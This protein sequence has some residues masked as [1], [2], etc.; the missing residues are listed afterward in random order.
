MN[1]LLVNPSSA[2]A[3]GKMKSPVQMHMGLA[4][5]AAVLEKNKHNVDIMDIDAEGINTEKFTELVKTRKYSIAGFTM[6]TPT[7]SSS[8]KLAELVK[9]HSPQT[10]TV[11]GGIHP[12][13]KPYEVAD[14]ECVDVVVKGEGEMALS[15][16]AEYVE[17]G[18][19]L[20][21]IKGIAYTKNGQVQ[22]SPP[23]L[24][25][26]DL[27]SIPFPARHLFKVKSYTYPDA[28][29]GDT[30]PIFTSR[31]CPGRCTFC[32]S[33][34][35]FETKVRVRSAR[36]VVDEIEYLTNSLHVKEIHVWDDNFTTIKDRVFKIRDEI[37]KR[38]LKVKF[39]FPNGIRADFLNIDIMKAL[40]DMG[41]YS[42]A[43]G[44][45]SGSQDVLDMAHKGVKLEKVEEIF[46]LARKMKF[47][48]WAFFIIGLPGENTNTIEQTIDFSK[49]ID[50]DIAKYHILKPYPKTEVYD[51]LN[52]R[53]F[54]LT[55]DYNRFGIHEPPIHRL[56]ALTPQDMLNWQKEAYK[57]FYFRPGKML[58]Q[59]LRIKSF[60][61][62]ILNLKA[63]LGLM[64]LLF[65]KE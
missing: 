59:M 8:V 56:E 53:G 51:Y 11:F 7:F 10:K 38:K 19:E 28:L 17:G 24:L 61:R 34:Q 30:A 43:V 35:I 22:E 15:E 65:L 46:A 41:T 52:S 31:G 27:D 5:I 39:A 20:S 3:Y 50:P 54:I 47:E 55:E 49:K 48:T 16:I 29:Y 12:T 13:I 6:T 40:R 45:E 37:V 33:R 64:K 2:V 63:G 36:N 58:N 1:I 18:R 57:S 25:I 32:N 21:T 60:N 14:L 42:I 26:D 62:L 44:V 23:R 4:Y 9:R